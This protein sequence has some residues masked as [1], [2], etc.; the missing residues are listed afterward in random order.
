M[1][2]IRLQRIGKKKQPSYRL[3]VSDKTKDTQ[4]G[5]LEILGHYNPITNPKVIEFKADRIKYW[6]S[7]GAQLSNTVN[8]LLLKQGIIQGKKMKSV[9]VSKKRQTKIEKEKADKAAKTEKPTEALQEEV[10]KEE[11]AGE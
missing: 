5:N 8:N 9:A 1:L 2:M 7:V 3:I 4:A 10:K 6:I 11:K